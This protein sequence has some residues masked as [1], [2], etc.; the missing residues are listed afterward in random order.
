LSQALPA[1]ALI[2]AASALTAAGLAL[3]RKP[4]PPAAG[5]AAGAEARIAG[6][7]GRIGELERRAGGGAAFVARGGGAESNA[8][9]SGAAGGE[10]TPT[11]GG[12]VRPD[13]A[14]PA[15]DPLRALV[16][17][18]VAEELEA[19]KARGEDGAK[20][21]PGGE[22]KPSLA[23]FGALL[24][25]DEGQRSAVQAAVVKG[26]EDLIALLRTPTAGGRV[27][28]DELLDTLL[29]KP[30]E[31]Q[32][33][34][35]EILTMLGTEKVPGGGETYGQRSE[36]LKRSVSESFRRQF[37]AEQFKEYERMGQDPLE[38]QVPDS[39]WIE[40]LRQA[41]ERRK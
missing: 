30:E 15:E 7:E 4:A 9:L 11:S 19:Q 29:G 32:P 24:D 14:P 23:Q 20:T 8:L 16:R 22:K 13:G 28:L 39:P 25:L 27:P 38:I 21:P 18:T 17:A 1:L 3:A 26:Q 34:M 10:A 35:M 31:M 12:G 2:V 40:V 36:N 37:R 33:R 5:G 6:L 41:V